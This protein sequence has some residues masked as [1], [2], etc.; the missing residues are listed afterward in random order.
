VN[1]KRTKDKKVREGIRSWN[2]VGIRNK[3]YWRYWKGLEVKSGM[4]LNT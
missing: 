1:R 2:V 4:G 3:E